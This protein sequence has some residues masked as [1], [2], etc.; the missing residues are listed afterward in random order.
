MKDGYDI[1]F[2]PIR[3]TLYTE[4][5][6]F[7]LNTTG[8]TGYYNYVDGQ[9]WT[10]REKTDESE[11]LNKIYNYEDVTNNALGIRITTDGRIGYR[12]LTEKTCDDILT[13]GDTSNN[14]RD[15]INGYYWVDR[16]DACTDTYWSELITP[17]YKVIEQYTQEPVMTSKEGRLTNIMIVFERY[18]PVV[19]ACELKYSKFRQGTLKIFVNGFKVLSAHGVEEMFPR[20]LDTVKELQEAVPFVM[21]MGGGTQGLYEAVYLDHLKEVD[22]LLEKFFAGTYTGY[23]SKFNFYTIPANITM[24]RNRVKTVFYDYGQTITFGGRKIYTF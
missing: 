16:Y 9:Y 18:F 12:L 4:E 21:S 17:Q 6:E 10:G 15:P 19:S 3:T 13:T 24:I 1:D 20:E 22:G 2:G 23:L 7:L 14:G 11:R 8:Y 5:E